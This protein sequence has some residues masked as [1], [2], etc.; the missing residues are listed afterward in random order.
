M[1]D[2]TRGQISADN[3]RLIAVYA[4]KFPPYVKA[5]M[6]FC[7]DYRL[8]VEGEDGASTCGRSRIRIRMTNGRS[9]IRLK[10]PPKRFVAGRSPSALRST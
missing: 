9:T 6:N 7:S 8:S 10:A 4:D 5:C 1:T 2:N 3:F